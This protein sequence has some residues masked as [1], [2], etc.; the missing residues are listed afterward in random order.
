MKKD[1]QQAYLDGGHVRGPGTGTSDSI[2]ANLSNDEFVVKADIVN[3]PGVLEFLKALNSGKVHL[4]KFQDGGLM[5]QAKAI[6]HAIVTP[7][8]VQ[9][10]V[11]QNPGQANLQS[12]LVQ[13]TA[14]A[15]T[16]SFS[17]NIDNSITPTPNAPQA[18]N[19]GDASSDLNGIN[20]QAL[21][22]QVDKIN[23][24]Q[25]DSKKAE[26]KEQ[27]INQL[28]NSDI[29][30]DKIQQLLSTNNFAKGGEVGH[31][32]LF[33]D[34]PYQEP[35]SDA[36]APA[37]AHGSL[38]EDVR[39]PDSSKV[40]KT[41]AGRAALVG[42]G[43][44]AT[45]GFGDEITSPVA[46]AAFDPST[47]LGAM[48]GLAKNAIFSVPPNS[49]EQDKLARFQDLMQQYRDVARDEQKSA[50][51]EHPYA[52]TGGAIAGG[53][54]A[55]GL[56][57]SGAIKSIGASGKAVEAGMAAA[58]ASKLLASG[59]GLA[60]KATGGAVL[61]AGLGALNGA[62]E[63]TGNLEDRLPGALEGAETGAKVGAA[64]P[65]VGATLVGGKQA[66]SSAG[67]KIADIPVVSDMI[68]AFK[69]GAQGQ[70]L[71]TSAGRRAASDAVRDQSGKLYEDI[72]QLKQNVGTKIDSEIGDAT[73]SGT[74]I[75]LTDDVNSVLDKL[76]AIKAT[77]SKEAASHADG[78]ERE[79]KKV[80][81]L[82]AET[83]DGSFAGVPKED[84]PE[85]LIT[86][87]AEESSPQKVQVTPE[88]AQDLKQVLND[89]TP[90]KGMAPQQIE[91]AKIA[92][93]LR[94]S[95]GDKLTDAVTALGD[96]DFVDESGNVQTS[97]GL[98]SQ[99]GLIKD[100]LK[101][102]SVNETRLPEQIKQK[103]NDT[104]TKLDSENLSGD[105]ARA[106]IGDVL[107]NIKQVSPEIADK[108]SKTFDD[109]V[110]RLNLSN[111]IT[112]GSSSIL[113]TP[114]AF[115]TAGANVAGLAANKVGLG[116]AFS[117][118]QT[119]AA[120]IMK[121]GFE[122]KTESG[123]PTVAAKAGQA[124]DDA[125]NTTSGVVNKVKNF[126]NTVLDSAN[127]TDARISGS[128][129]SPGTLSR[130]KDAQPYQYQRQ[131][132]QAASNADPD[133]LKQQAAQVRQQYGNQGEQ[134]ATI[135]EKM[136]DQGKDSR[137]ALMFTVMQNPAY[138]KMLGVTGEAQ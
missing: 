4:P 29:P 87:D 128:I 117:G 46:A 90:R 122:Y 100:S 34:V 126:A 3:Q 20:P 28:R 98:N 36:K 83:E 99:Y 76:K 1:K 43:Q 106:M 49:E 108:Y 13:P 25:D 31:N 80:L 17:N 86:P 119:A 71:I 72:S 133:T 82:K 127:S 130:I 121:S 57:A 102:L 33:E 92:K 115:V 50:Q 129:N 18:A 134:L 124:L 120:P 74:K 37:S 7:G 73:E 107:D 75:D 38:F 91:P 55:P 114:R 77:G 61:G 32:D 132:A 26:L 113:G 69:R 47:A 66:L 94:N 95:T 60:T 42:A 53:L 136:A 85:G 79:I 22:N 105:N 5:N 81:G 67:S 48:K 64:I 89:Y 23:S 88:Q 27:L 16:P 51:S 101:R 52:Y 8:K 84:Q 19:L 58:G 59:A 110:E 15:A 41:T 54:L 9:N 109:I 45:F 78:I 131:V 137:T 40:D 10:D 96:K 63:A 24:T 111:K 35:D 123:P 12:S 56:G 104:V 135:L 97:P 62:G 30:L 125:G 70:N 21:K 118:A 14:A 103:I 93:D 2:P 11:L 68:G 65:V 6:G 39:H 44:G 116:N 112:Q 138:K